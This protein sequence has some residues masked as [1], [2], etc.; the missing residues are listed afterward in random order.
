[1]SR[2][3]MIVIMIL[4]AAVVY[5]LI[6]RER[7]KQRVE[8]VQQIIT[9]EVT[10]RDIGKTTDFLTE[11]FKSNLISVL[12]EKSFVEG[13]E[14]EELYTNVYRLFLPGKL[15]PAELVVQ[16]STCETVQSVHTKTE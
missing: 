11:Y 9:C 2:E 10:Y 16:L 3:M 5:G 13:G 6:R 8:R 4:A 1:M 12:D 7:E 14:D 15:A